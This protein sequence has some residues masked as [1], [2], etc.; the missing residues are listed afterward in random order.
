MKCRKGHDLTNPAI[1]YRWR[2][3]IKC[4][5]CKRAQRVKERLTTPIA[6]R[7]VQDVTRTDRLMQLALMLEVA[8]P[9]ERGAI[10][11]E[12]ERVRAELAHA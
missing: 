10:E 5:V 2:G 12:I 7:A 8:M 4:R 9:W 11:A 3:K 6:Q 1:A